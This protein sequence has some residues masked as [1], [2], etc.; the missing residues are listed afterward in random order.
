MSYRGL[1]NLHDELLQ[2]HL[3]IRKTLRSIKK[4]CY[5]PGIAEEIKMY[6]KYCEKCQMHKYSKNNK[7]PRGEQKN[8]MAPGIPLLLIIW[9]RSPD[10]SL[11]ISTYCS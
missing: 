6:L 4:K 10:Q 3:G 9:I 7:V 8:V 1:K 2:V 11:E 5:W